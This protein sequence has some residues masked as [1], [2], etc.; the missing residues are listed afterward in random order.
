MSSLLIFFEL[1]SSE[2]L[3]SKENSKISASAALLLLAEDVEH[4]V[5]LRLCGKHTLRKLRKEG[6]WG[7]MPAEAHKNKLF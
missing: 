1:Y 4:E 2:I 7:S 5:M 6:G 3:L